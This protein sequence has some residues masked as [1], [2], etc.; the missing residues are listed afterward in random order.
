MHY[1]AVWK[2]CEADNE[3]KGS[4]AKHNKLS[5]ALCLSESSGVAG[6][7]GGADNGGSGLLCCDGC[8]A[9]YHLR[10]LAHDDA[11]HDQ[12]AP[13]G[14]VPISLTA[15]VLSLGLLPRHGGWYCRRC[16]E[17]KRHLPAGSADEL[18]SM[19]RA[20]K[21]A[22]IATPHQDRKDRRDSWVAAGRPRMNIC[23]AFGPCLNSK[24]RT[25]FLC[26]RHLFKTDVHAGRG[27]VYLP[28]TDPSCTH[29]KRSVCH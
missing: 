14:Y 3:W 18:R 16:V 19:M 15:G 20:R 29:C 1:Y 10:C 11:G 17:A 12:S 28:I 25:P 21:K 27:Y 26:Q 2:F 4:T 7:N 8:P 9:A 22:R 5:C 24:P 6:V 13:E 23:S